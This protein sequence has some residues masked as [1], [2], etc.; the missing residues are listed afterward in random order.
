MWNDEI[1]RFILIAKKQIKTNTINIKEGN[2]IITEE[3]IEELIKERKL[4]NKNIII[5]RKKI[6]L[7]EDPITNK[8][9]ITE[10]QDAPE[11]NTIRDAYIGFRQDI[12]RKQL[13]IQIARD[14]IIS[15]RNIEKLKQKITEQ[16]RKVFDSITQDYINE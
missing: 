4:T 14:D 6:I 1:I 5:E 13:N 12:N 15:D 9:R 2:P 11:R 7:T 3:T 8:T 10:M 16:T